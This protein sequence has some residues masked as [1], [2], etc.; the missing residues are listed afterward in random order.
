MPTEVWESLPLEVRKYLVQK[1]MENAK[2]TQ[3]HL[4]Y[5]DPVLL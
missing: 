4:T 2:K 3:G 1:R 5:I